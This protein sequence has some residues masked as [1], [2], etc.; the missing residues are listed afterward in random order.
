[1]ISYRNKCIDD[2]I[3]KYPTIDKDLIK[4]KYISMYDREW[5][6]TWPTSY[7]MFNVAIYFKTD[8]ILS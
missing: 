6:K 3:T 2:L 8:D 4:Q 5:D 7:V 1:M